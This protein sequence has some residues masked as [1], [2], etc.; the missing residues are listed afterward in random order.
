MLE[1]SHSGYSLLPAAFIQGQHSETFRLTEIFAK[2][3]VSLQKL[4]AKTVPLI[5]AYSCIQKR[6]LTTEVQGY[7]NHATEC[8][9]ALSSI[10]KM[11]HFLQEE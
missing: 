10:S 7:K 6:Y 8:M 3:S 5:F 11:L 9:A 1:C 4:S 2:I